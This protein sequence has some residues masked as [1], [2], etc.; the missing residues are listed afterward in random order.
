MTPAH[1]IRD[2]IAFRSTLRQLKEPSFRILAGVGECPPDIQIEALA[3]CFTLLTANAGLDAHEL[4][5]RARR[6]I[7]DADRVDNPH[8]EAIADFAKGELA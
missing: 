5:A 4:V 8:L 3:L 6:Q 7:A 2:R 1:T